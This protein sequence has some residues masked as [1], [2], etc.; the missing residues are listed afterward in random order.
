MELYAVK[1]FKPGIH[2]SDQQSLFCKDISPLSL[3][4]MEQCVIVRQCKL[5]EFTRILADRDVGAT[6]EK[7]RDRQ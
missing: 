5:H 7:E 6:R 4:N 1:F 2:P 3:C